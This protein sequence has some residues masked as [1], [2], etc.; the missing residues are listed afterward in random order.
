MSYKAKKKF[1]QNFLIDEFI[2]Q[3]IISFLDIQK[4]DQLFEIGPGFGALSQHL[5]NL[6]DNFYAIEID[7]DLIGFLNKKY[8][9][10][11]IINKSLLDIDFNEYSFVD[12]RFIGNLPYNISTA[13]LMHL[14]KFKDLIKDMLFMFQLEV[15]KRIVSKKDNKSYGRLSVISQYLWQVETVLDV[16]K[17]CFNPMPKVQSAVVLFKKQNRQKYPKCSL[18]I[19]SFIT[20]ESFKMRRKTIFNNLKN[21]FTIQE[22][23]SININPKLR[24]EN[25]SVLDY[26]NLAN[27]YQ[28]NNTKNDPC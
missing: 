19:L 26:V 10:I 4:S 25:L 5:T 7:K 11:K 12:I 6:S 18:S 28:K 27:I 8:P 1:G 2:I 24:A 21:I 17:S 13:I 23:N 15:A 20:K 3:K 14:A 16:D 22:L 9:N